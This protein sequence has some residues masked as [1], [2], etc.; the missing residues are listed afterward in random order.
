MLIAPRAKTSSRQFVPHCRREEVSLT[1]NHERRLGAL[2]QVA[3]DPTEQDL[4]DAGM[5]EPADRDQIGTDFLRIESQRLRL[6]LVVVDD[7]CP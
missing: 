5:S 1:N 3:G 7:Q 2:E 4:A 6:A